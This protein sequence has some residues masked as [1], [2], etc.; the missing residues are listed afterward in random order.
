MP[1]VAKVVWVPGHVLVVLGF[2]LAIALLA[3]NSIGLA[4]TSCAVGVLGARALL[5]TGALKQ[6]PRKR[7]GAIIV[8]VL[9]GGLFLFLVILR[10]AVGPQA[11]GG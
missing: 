7:L 5:L 8:S 6:F 9:G 2:L 4:V 3:G 10:V 11:W 1:A